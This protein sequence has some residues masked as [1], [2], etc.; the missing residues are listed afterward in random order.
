MHSDSDIEDSK[1]PLM[2]HIIEF[3]NRL[4]YSV[5]TVLVT[6]ILCYLVSEELFAFLV[7]PLVAALGDDVEGRRMIFTGLHE[8]FFTNIKIA[9]F[10]ALFIS[11]PIV[12]TQIWAFV[13]PGL[14]KHEK[15][16]FLPFLVVTPVLFFLG[17]ALA[18]EI[19]M[20][21]AW[22]FL[23]SFETGNSASLYSKAFT[24]LTSEYPKMLE[25]LPAPS[26][27]MALPIQA[28]TRVSEYL[29]L[30]MKLIFAFGLCFQLPVLLTLLGRVGIVTSQGLKE[31]FKYSIVF[32]FIAA[33]ILTPPDPLSQITLAIP[34]ILLYALSI[35]S[36]RMVE[37]KRE[38]RAA[39]EE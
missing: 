27:P 31:K 10:V 23:L 14:Y 6:F 16:A 12:A 18:Y 17:G 15:K 4:V 8:A 3:R 2:E 29:S 32:A 13:A 7:R 1:A 34:I 30:S 28:E 11:F 39:A 25:F 21:L 35:V 20:P 38:E 9:F 5:L 36:V 22:K 37:K 33:A 19:V 26:E 24:A